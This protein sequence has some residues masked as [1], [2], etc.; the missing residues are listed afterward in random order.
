MHVSL[1]LNITDA[2]AVIQTFVRYD[3]NIAAV[4]MDDSLLHDMYAERFDLFMKYLNL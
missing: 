4:Y 1:K 3:Y 2:S